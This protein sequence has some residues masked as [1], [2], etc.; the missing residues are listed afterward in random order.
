M[1]KFP[2]SFFLLL[3]VGNLTII[4]QDSL[5]KFHRLEGNNGE[6]LGNI[7]GI[8]QDRH[9]YMWLSGQQAQCLYR[10]DGNRILTFRHDSL[11]ANSLG[12]TNL[13]TVYADATGTIWIGF[14]NGGLDRYDPATNTFTHY[15]HNPNDDG[16]ISPGMVNVILQDQKGIVWVGT[17]NGLDRLDERTGKFIHYRS[18]PTDSSTLSSNV[19]RSLYQDRSGVLWV[20]TG[21][22]FDITKPADG[23]LNRMEPDGSFTRFIHDPS[24]PHSLI[25]NKVRSI[26]EDSRG[27][28]WVGTGGDGL[29]TMNRATG[30]FER[31][32][33]SASNH[34]KLSRP[35]FRP[36]NWFDHITFIKE[37]GSGQIW[38]GTFS[39][40]MNRYNPVTKKI[41]HFEASNGFPD[42]SSWMAY[43]SNDGVLWISAGE[44]D[45][46]LYRFDPF[47]KPIKTIQTP[48]KPI[49][50]LEDKQGV[51]WV[52]VLETGLFQYDENKKLIRQFRKDTGNKF[53]ILNNTVQSIFENEKD[54]FWL[55]TTEGIVAFSKSN[56]R[57][58]RFNYNLDRDGKPKY[59][60][61]EINQIIKDKNGLTWIASSGGLLVFDHK[62]ETARRF[63]PD[64]ADAGSIN[65]TRISCLLEDRTGEIWVGTYGGQGINRLDKKRSSFRHY[66]INQN[67]TCL[68][69]DSHGIIWAGTEKGLYRYDKSTDQFVVFFDEEVN[70]SSAVVNGIIE[71]DSSELW[72]STQSAIVRIDAD[73]KNSLIYEKKFGIR[74]N[75][76][77]GSKIYK[78]SKGEIVVGHSNGFYYFTPA[79]LHLSKI[80]SWIIITDLFV[81]KERVLAGGNILHKPIEEADTITLEHKQNN[82]SLL[83][84]STDFRDPESNKFYTK[85]EGYDNIWRQAT[86]SKIAFFVNIPAG[87]Y[88]FKVKVFNS[89]G[90]STEKSVHIHIKP[91]WWKT[92]WAYVL[93][94]LL[95]VTF[96]STLYHYLKRRAI[97]IERQKS[98]YKELLQTRE[99]AKAYAQLKATQAQLIH[100][101]KMASLGELT[102]GIAHEIQNPLNFVN[103]F[104]E[105]NKELLLEIREEISKGNFKEVSSLAKEVEDNQDKINEHG[106]R[107]ESIVKGMLLHSR[108]SSGQKELHDINKQADEYLRLSYHGFRAKNKDFNVAIEKDYDPSVG[109][110]NIIPQDIGRVLL[111]L[112]NNA[113]YAVNEKNA[114]QQ[115]GYEPTVAVTTKRTSETIMISIKDNGNGIPE[116]VIDKIFQPF[117][118]TKPTGQGTGLGLSLAY[119]IIKVHGGEIKVNSIEGAFTEFVVILPV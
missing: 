3:L 93:Y 117:F 30:K 11:N 62:R 63:L 49:S 5:L 42:R 47:I 45:R 26:F 13:E 31:H 38:I 61:N 16:T 64:S 53:S 88:V 108:R 17:A 55:G 91:Q 40:G 75:S 111:N 72:L 84:A 83:F 59:G 82:L 80:P 104:S 107:A 95:F 15:F 67:V 29:H 33:Y 81:N 78:T 119:D 99:I 98:D 79:E 113:F 1:L 8:T 68:L 92:N 105:V 65:S 44:A 7:T 71:D 56:Y 37:D 35:P 110:I 18:K 48:R 106:K 28:F 22:P 77:L 12:G 14:F 114:R 118:T 86:G 58:T 85:L 34:S 69:E 100:S 27:T 21:F 57:F 4:A 50:F 112:F 36:E 109:C 54:S 23:G 70:L 20:G 102:A 87:A 19:V 60:F 24:N 103:N 6:P 89:D 115:Q 2:T 90:V 97:R 52:G 76:L 41:T 101:E 32:T 66:V 39:A 51:L 9:G 74:P 116:R 96:M 25:N 46:N 43:K 73:R 10:Y 94:V